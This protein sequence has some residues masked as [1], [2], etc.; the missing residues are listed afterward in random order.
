MRF[1]YDKMMCTNTGTRLANRAG[2]MFSPCQK[3]RI[4]G[5][6]GHTRCNLSAQSASAVIVKSSWLQLEWLGA[7]AIGK[8]C[9]KW[10]IWLTEKTVAYFPSIGWLGQNTS[11]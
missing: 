3:K 6:T 1:A 7:A 5:Q 8:P 10:C 2:E 4:H 9:G 11:Q